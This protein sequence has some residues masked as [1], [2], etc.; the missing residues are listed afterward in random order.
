M[1]SIT[2]QQVR[3][4]INMFYREEDFLKELLHGESC[5]AC[6]KAVTAGHLLSCE[7]TAGPR[8]MQHDA[9][10]INL[11][12]AMNKSRQASCTP[13]KITASRHVNAREEQVVIYD[14]GRFI[15]ED[16]RC[17]SFDVSIVPEEKDMDARYKQKMEKYRLP[18]GRTNDQEN[19]ILIPIIA[20]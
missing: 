3:M 6:G 16:K 2:D 10:C 17:Y 7:R 12:N 18:E 4:L 20:S 11:A 5:E 19:P 1:E 8:N 13:K 15:G 14:D 9:I